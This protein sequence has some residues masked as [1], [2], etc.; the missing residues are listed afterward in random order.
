MKQK[1]FRLWIKLRFG[2]L[3]SSYDMGGS[4]IV[5]EHSVFDRFGRRVGFCSTGSFDPS[6]PYRGKDMAA[7]PFWTAEWKPIFGT[8]WLTLCLCL[9]VFLNGMVIALADGSFVNTFL[10]ALALSYLI[11]D[12]YVWLRRIAG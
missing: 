11:Y 8:I 1:L 2:K 7:Y 4:G 6:F 9:F 12:S 5:Y 3:S 10:P